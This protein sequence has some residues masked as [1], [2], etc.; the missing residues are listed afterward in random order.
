MWDAVEKAFESTFEDAH[1]DKLGFAK[2]IDRYVTEV[3]SPYGGHRAWS[4]SSTTSGS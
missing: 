4:R 2:V 3:R 1:V